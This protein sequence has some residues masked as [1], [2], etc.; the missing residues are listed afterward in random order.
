MPMFEFE[1][2][3]CRVEFEEL[4][5]NTAAVRDV[6]CPSCGSAETK[7]RVSTFAS[8]M[9]QSAKAAPPCATGACCLGGN[10]GQN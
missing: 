7:K 8:R 9:G 5:P 6:K 10:C 4:V 1:C 2:A 3:E